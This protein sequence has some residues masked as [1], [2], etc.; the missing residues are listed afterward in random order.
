MEKVEVL[1]KYNVGS[2]P[3]EEVFKSYKELG[4]W[5]ARNYK[6]AKAIFIGV[7]AK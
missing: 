2:K 3:H 6:K 5:Y 4:E 1:V 7:K